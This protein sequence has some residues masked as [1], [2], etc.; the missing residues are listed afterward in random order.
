[1]GKQLKCLGI[2]P[3]GNR[4]YAYKHGLS[5]EQGYAKGI[6]RAWD[7]LEWL[8]QFPE[9]EEVCFYTLSLKNF[10]RSKA[11]LD[12][13]LRMLG[14][15]LREAS[16]NP[17]FERYGIRVR[18]VGRIHLLPRDIQQA[19]AKLED[20]T[21]EFSNRTV[22]LALAYDGQSEIVDA[23]KRLLQ[24]RNTNPLSRSI[25][26]K[27]FVKYLY[28]P[29]PE[30]DFIIRTSGTQRLSGFFTYQAS[31]AELYFSEKLW[32][33]FTIEDLNKAIEFYRST[34]RKFGR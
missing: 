10:E 9:I 18:C 22:Y 4:R 11:E 15:Q 19:V 24:E 25:D 14:E 21:K 33:E 8:Q 34:E 13:L 3:D 26:E 29:I 6:E 32:P 1:M 2:I 5:L 27:E 7:V 12:L 30:I 31:Y 20:A 17:V 23:A 28:A 16:A